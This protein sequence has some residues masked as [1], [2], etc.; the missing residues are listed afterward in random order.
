MVNIRLLATI[1]SVSA[2][3]LL[4][5][6]CSSGSAPATT[7]VPTESAA[8]EDLPAPETS[9]RESGSRV[10]VIDS[11]QSSAS[12]MVDEEFLPDML[13]KYGIPA[14]RGDTIGTTPI[15]EGTLELNLDDLST[16]LGENSFRAD[17]SQLT[18]DQALRDQW[19]Q[20]QGPQFSQ[21]PDAVFV[22]ESV[23]NAPDE[24]SEGDEV[25]F[26]LV[27]EIT[28]REITNPVT[29]EVSATLIGGT[30]TGTAA[31]NLRL[32]DFDIEPPNFANTLR[33]EDEFQL[34]VDFVANEQ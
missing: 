31:A 12:Y 7:P 23:D 30:L 9:T 6:A 8:V 32:T 19:L 28:I 15:V 14:G 25:V 16:P 34:R 22:A 11:E 24:Y 26:E 5:V 20:Q 29:F 33:V 21:Y 2:I 10:F 17:L 3:L 18:S 27:G 4:T 1:G 13:S